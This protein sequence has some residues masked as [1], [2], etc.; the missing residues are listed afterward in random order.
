MELRIASATDRGK[1]REQNED[2]VLTDLPLVAVADGMGG[3][4]AGEVASSLALDA[5]AEWKQRLTGTSGAAAGE[6]LRQA[7]DAANRSVW[8]KGRG[9]EELQGMGTTLTAAWIEGDTVA[10]GHVG[11]SRAYLLREG[12][13]RQLTT[14]QNVAQDLVRR[15]RISEDEAA[16]SPHRHIIL[17]AIGADATGLDIEVGSVELQESDRFVLATDGMFGMVKS[18]DRIRDILVERS[19]P[20]EACRALVDAANEAG[21]EDNISVVVIDVLATDGTAGVVAPSAVERPAPVTPPAT[22]SEDGTQRRSRLSRW[23]V[24]VG[25]LALVAVVVGGLLIM[26]VGSN[27]LLV[28]E[29][30]GTVVV[31]R[32]KP[33]TSGERATGDVIKVLPDRLSRFP[34]TVREDLREGIP[35]GSLR[36]AR[37]VV[38]DLPRLLGPQDTPE[39]SPSGSPTPSS[40]APTQ[41]A[42]GLKAPAP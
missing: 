6:L 7:F 3:H 21:G 33:G 36:E 4:K 38:A 11:D 25:A 26:R 39:P 18:P 13:L 2:S 27:T 37:R 5:L 41:A 12:K 40:P 31:L 28:A 9:D 10:L 42:L 34:K 35:V 16:S 30:N 8:E 15:G 14:D 24:V 19:D 20:A 23:P 1:V 32:G 22:K 29:R 17:Q